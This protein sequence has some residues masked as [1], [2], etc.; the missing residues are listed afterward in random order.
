MLTLK[1]GD[2]KNKIT[3]VRCD[4]N[5]GVNDKGA[6]TDDFRIRQ[7]IPTI[8]YLIGQEA[9][10]VLMSHL[11]KKENLL[12]QK[13]IADR[14]EQLLGLQVAFMDDCVGPQVL[15]RVKIGRASCR[16]RVYENV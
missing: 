16:E 1:Q 7:A 6:I 4:F 8:R 11:E 12:S 10:V 9:V 13:I 14:L 5:V 15:D 2:F 3:L